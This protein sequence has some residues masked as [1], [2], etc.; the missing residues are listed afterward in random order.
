VTGGVTDATGYHASVQW[1]D[2][3]VPQDA[4][5][6]ASGA[7]SGQHTYAQTGTYTVHVT[8][9][10]TL[11]SST[12][13][14]TVTVGGPGAQPAISASPSVG[15]GDTITVNGTG[16]AAGEQV[17]V[18]LNAVSNVTV[19]ASAAGAVHASLAAPSDAEPGLYAV[20]AEGA[21]SQAPATATVEMTEAAQP[22]YRPEVTLSDTE[23]PRGTA[24]TVNGS[25]FARNEAVTIT[26]GDGL[27]TMT[28]HANGDGV[29]SGAVISVPGAAV[30]GSTSLTLAGAD[31]G[32]KVELPF[33]V[34][35]QD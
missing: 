17:S 12:A 22:A 35:N 21:S 4:T 28:V 14:F 29:I 30:P 26:F 20:T 25:G 16:F 13:T 8:A 7:I 33:T 34:T 1:G 19:K 18:T 31:S 27:H 9:W 24:I 10:D 23:G 6:N 32:A 11:S 15:A 3:T 5:V 2:G